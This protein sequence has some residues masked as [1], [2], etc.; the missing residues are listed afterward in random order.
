MTQITG[1][2]IT[3][4]KRFVPLTFAT[5]AFVLACGGPAQRREQTSPSVAAPVSITIAEE[6]TA[7]SSITLRIAAGALHAGSGV[8]YTAARLA[9]ASMENAGEPIVEPDAMT[10]RL[11]CD[12]WSDCVSAAQRVAHPVLDEATFASAHSVLIAQRAGS[13]MDP[14]QLAALR[15]A[16]GTTFTAR[17]S[18]LGDPSSSGPRRDDVF[19]FVREYFAP[20]RFTWTVT[21]PRNREVDVAVLSRE[22]ATAGYSDSSPEANALPQPERRDPHLV[23]IDALPTAEPCVAW[24]SPTLVRTRDLLNAIVDDAAITDVRLVAHWFRM[25]EVYG[26]L[27][28]TTHDADATGTPAAWIAR[29]LEHAWWLT[30]FRESTA[31]PSISLAVAAPTAMPGMLGIEHSEH[32]TDVRETTANGTITFSDS[33]SRVMTTPGDAAY[34]TVAVSAVADTFR[35]PPG[36]HGRAALLSEALARSCSVREQ[37]E[38]RA[39]VGDGQI[40]LLASDSEGSET[41]LLDALSRC[42]AIAVVDDEYVD[43]AKTEL[44]SRME[45][46]RAQAAARVARLIAPGTPTEVTPL[47]AP[48]ELE[49]LTAESLRPLLREI[50]RFEAAVVGRQADEQ[51]ERVREWARHRLRRFP[52]RNPSAPRDWGRSLPGPRTVFDRWSGPETRAVFAFTAPTVDGAAAAAEDL[53][54]R[55]RAGG[56]T[57]LASYTRRFRR[58]AWSACVVSA[59]ENTVIDRLIETANTHLG[60]EGMSAG[61]PSTPVESPQ[62]ASAVTRALALVA[63]PDNGL[64]EVPASGPY[65]LVERPR[66]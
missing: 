36:A 13:H 37:I 45:T 51:R 7:R 12:A 58:G 1:P 25:G 50:E 16:F 59:A 5:L 53:A 46:L 66:R 28:C 29:V 44:R 24:W 38:A 27:A 60:G 40:V 33:R 19:A 42:I 41:R 47:G 56:A 32:G 6:A 26:G 14:V 4:C 17:A 63:L 20:A 48:G 22:L 8:A 30:P 64:P 10:F 2:Q 43:A 34:V 31:M 18:P 35:D 39:T 52:L 62:R 23:R 3:L 9:V 54:R 21:R 61:S 49:R 55:A 15:G 57:V 11:E 65:V